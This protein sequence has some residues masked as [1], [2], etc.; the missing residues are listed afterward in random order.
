MTIRVPP[1]GEDLFAG[2]EQPR[3]E[4]PVEDDFAMEQPGPE[5]PSLKTSEEASEKLKASGGDSSNKL[6]SKKRKTSVILGAVVLL[7]VVAL[8]AGLIPGWIRDGSN[9]DVVSPMYAGTA[10]TPSPAPAAK[11]AFFESTEGPF[12]VKLP[13]F[14][15]NVIQPYLSIDDARSD[16]VQLVR[17]SVNQAIL[18]GMKFDASGYYVG[19]AVPEGDMSQEDSAGSEGDMSKEDSASGT[20]DASFEGVDD[21]DTYQHE[22]GVTKSDFVKSTGDLVFAA[23][24]DHL[25]VWNLQGELLSTITLPPLNISSGQNG[26]IY[27]PPIVNDGDVPEGDNTTKDEAG[28]DTTTAK[29]SGDSMWYNPKPYF[30]GLLL[31]EDGSR[32]TAIVGGYGMELVAAEDNLPVTY[33]YLAT[34]VI[35]YDIQGG[36]LTQVSQTDINGSHRNSYSVGNDVHIV[37]QSGL[38]TYSYILEP[39]SRWNPAFANMTVDEYKAAATALAEELIPKFVQKILDLYTVDGAIVLSRLA[40]FASSISENSEDDLSIFGSGIANAITEIV[41]FDMATPTTSNND[42]G[43]S[44]SATMQPGSWGYVYATSD[45][46][47]VADQGWNWVEAEDTY[48][49]ETFLLGFRLNDGATSSFSVVGTVPG[50]ILNQFAIDFVA[51]NGAEFI[52]VATTLNFNWGWWGRPM[53]ADSVAQ[54]TGESRTKNQV[55]ILQ[56]PSDDGTPED[57]ELIKRGSVELGKVNEVSRES[58]LFRKY[59]LTDD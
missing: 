32:L 15:S 27:D 4:A 57:N 56:V 11:Q 1:G 51:E 6:T 5:T 19:E 18:E 25:H 31:N 7:A 42:F 28:L 22:A 8:L 20:G 12:S 17:F 47:W 33:D 24:E 58:A 14:S 30:H 41:S 39:L 2:K 45:W 40:V 49:Q 35:V 55:F 59:V 48:V 10:D 44:R 21:F 46:I 26:G 52:R 9:S 54:I 3:P 16:V 50:S 34:R 53:P 37:T 23:V 43:F 29:V 36:T 13:L 38:N